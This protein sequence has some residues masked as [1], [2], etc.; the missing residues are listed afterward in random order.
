MYTAF[1]LRQLDISPECENPGMGLSVYTA[2]NDIFTFF[3]MNWH[4]FVGCIVIKMGI[5]MVLRSYM[6]KERTE[7][8]KHQ[9]EWINEWMDWLIN[10]LI[11][12][13]KCLTI[14]L[15]PS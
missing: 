2:V 5:L 15:Q 3:F 6:I 14:I 8:K 11:N 7:E 12:K 13:F 1:I 9:H 4:H 10:E